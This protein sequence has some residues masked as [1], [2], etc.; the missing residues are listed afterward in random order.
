MSFGGNEYPS[1]ITKQFMFK[2]V[3]HVMLTQMGAKRG[4][5]KHGMKAV[6]AIF[7]ELKQLNNDAMP[8]KLVITP[9][10]P[11]K[12]SVDEN[13]RALEAVELIKEKE[14]EE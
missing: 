14:T 10:N 9:T 13:K 4:F 5:R 6:N 8:G 3:V 11:D 2:K 12:L 1:L 7:K